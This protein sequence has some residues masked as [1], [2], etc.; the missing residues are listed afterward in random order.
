MSSISGPRDGAPRLIDALGE[1]RRRHGRPVTWRI[2]RLANRRLAI[3]P[4]RR[5]GF[6][7][8]KR[9]P[10][11]GSRWPSFAPYPSR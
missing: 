8:V 6:S 7:A 10:S 4:R 1:H 2:E 5:A 11:P 3:K 9:K